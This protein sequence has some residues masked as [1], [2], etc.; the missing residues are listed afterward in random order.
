M[1]LPTIPI[2][3]PE[4]GEIVFEFLKPPRPK[5]HC[6]ACWHPRRAPYKHNHCAIALREKALSLSE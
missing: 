3:K 1:N 6:T 5:K 4:G 2:T